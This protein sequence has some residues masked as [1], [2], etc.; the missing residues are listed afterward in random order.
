[1]EDK[2]NYIPEMTDPLSK[3][4]KQPNRSEILLDD[5]YAVMTKESFGELAEYSCSVPSGQY[6]GKMWRSSYNIGRWTLR[7]MIIYPAGNGIILSR[8]ILI[9]D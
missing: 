3:C 9:V 6:S 4:W 7:W 5:D 8:E 2:F 1:M